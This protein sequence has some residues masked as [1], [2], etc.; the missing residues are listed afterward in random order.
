MAKEG[1][2]VKK[3]VKMTENG[4]EN[5]AERDSKKTKM[6]RKWKNLPC[7]YNRSD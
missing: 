6:G 4:G 7:E 2:V 5:G 1:L 3:A